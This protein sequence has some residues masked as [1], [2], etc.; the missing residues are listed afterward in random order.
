MPEQPPPTPDPG[1]APVP[2]PVT[3]VL[4][5]GQNVRGRLYSWHQTPTGWQGDVGL[6]LWR[7]GDDH[8]VEA[9]EYRVWLDAPGQLLQMPD[10]DYSAVP[11][12]R[13]PTPT[14]IAEALGERRPSGWVMQGLK[15]GQGIL[16]AP[17]CTEA[18]QGAVT[19]SLDQALTLAERQPAVRLCSLCGAAAELS[20]LLRG[21]DSGFD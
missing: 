6:P 14:L 5:D 9:A 21:F 13:L 3:V 15:H 2:V 16:H 11:A 18:P 7:N 12:V 19:L 4:A 10:V 17:D 20:P 1:D 8:V